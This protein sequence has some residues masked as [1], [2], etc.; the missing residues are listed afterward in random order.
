M[1][2]AHSIAMETVETVEGLREEH[3]QLV[4][5]HES[6][7]Q[8]PLYMSVGIMF[9]IGATGSRCR[10]RRLRHSDRTMEI[11][12]GSSWQ[13]MLPWSGSP[14]PD[15]FGASTPRDEGV[16]MSDGEEEGPWEHEMI[17]QPSA[18]ADWLV[19]PETKSAASPSAV[20]TAVESPSK[21]S[22][23]L[24]GSVE[25]GEG[26]QHDQM[27]SRLLDRLDRHKEIAQSDSLAA[28]AGSPTAAP[29][30]SVQHPEVE[31]LVRG[32]D[33]SFKDVRVMAKEKLNAFSPSVSWTIPSGIKTP[34][35]PSMAAKRHKNR[36]TVVSAIREMTRLKQLDGNHMA[37][38]M[39]LMGTMIDR[40]MI[41]APADW[42]NY[43]TTELAM[44]RMHGIERAFEHAKQ[45]SDWKPPNGAKQ[46]WKSESTLMCRRS[47]TAQ[48]KAVR[49]RANAAARSS[50]ALTTGCHDRL[51]DTEWGS[52][53]EWAMSHE[54]PRR[55]SER[56]LQRHRKAQDLR[57]HASDDESA[58]ERLALRRLGMRLYLH[59]TTTR[60]R[61][62]YEKMALP[63][64]Q[65]DETDIAN[66]RA[67]TDPSI[68][69]SIDQLLKEMK[70]RSM[71]VPS[72]PRGSR[73]LRLTVMLMSFGWSPA[74]CHGALEN[75]ICNLHGPPSRGQ[76]AHGLVPPSFAEVAFIYWVSMD[77]FAS[78]ALVSE[79]ESTI[80]AT[81]K[82]IARPRLTEVGL[83][84]HMD[85]PGDAIPLSL[86][87][88][89][90][91]KPHRLT[92]AGDKVRNV[93]GATRALLARGH[94]T[95]Q[96]LSRTVGSWVWSAM[97]CRSAFCPLD[98][99]YTFATKYGGDQ[100]RHELWE[101]A[102]NAQWSETAFAADASETGL[103][104]A[105]IEASWAE[106]KAEVDRQRRIQQLRDMARDDEEEEML[107]G[108]A[109]ECLKRSFPQVTGESEV[110]PQRWM[111]DVFAG[112]GGF[113]GKVRSERQ[114]ETP[115][116]DSAL[117]PRRD[118]MDPSFVEVVCQAILNGLFFLVHMARR[119]REGNALAQAAISMRVARMA[120]SAGFS[121][122]NP[123]A[124]LIWGLPEMIKLMDQEGAFA[125]EI[126][127]CAFGAKWPKPTGPLA[128]AA[129]QK[130]LDCLC[131]AR[132]KLARQAIDA[133]ELGI[134]DWHL[135]RSPMRWF[136][137]LL[138]LC[139]SMATAGAARK[140]KGLP[141]P[142]MTQLRK[143]GAITL[144]TGARLTLRWTPTDM[145]PADGPSR[146]E[147]VGSAEVTKTKAEQ[148]KDV[149]DSKHPFERDHET[150][151]QTSGMD[152]P[153]NK[154]SF[155]DDK[156]ERPLRLLIHA[157]QDDAN[158]RYIKEVEPFVREVHRKP[159]P[160]SSPG[161]RDITVAAE[162]DRRCFAER[163]PLNKGT[164][165][166]HGLMHINPEWKS[167]MP[168]AL[169]ALHSWERHQETWEEGLASVDAI[170]YIS[171]EAVQR[172]HAD[173]GMVFLL[174][175]DCYLR[176][177]DWLQLKAEDVHVSYRDQA[178]PRSINA[179]ILLGRRHRG[180]SVKTY[181]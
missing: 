12:T 44:W 123:G 23:S 56:V 51:R 163:A 133:R 154:I 180:E 47:R 124:P 181:R 62:I 120:A 97:R 144:A 143:I 96:E 115:F 20:P 145:N 81:V 142:L 164:M 100:G 26:S 71:K 99:R 93:I 67:Y 95:S 148:K 177:Q 168:N 40:S 166:H 45:R 114:C 18:V 25:L 69:A 116:V 85:G 104:A 33:D 37:E 147:S 3:K 70:R 105:E 128:N 136:R 118:L 34:V 173:E 140:I 6:G 171:R 160:F 53:N 178:D 66:T 165:L 16:A 159:L 10:G 135:C 21:P 121:P 138:V 91:E 13:L 2:R 110:P 14:S 158:V 129:A 117:D 5:M 126:A 127:H 46:E 106:V 130:D 179:A 156:L 155:E 49:G 7:V 82:E 161:E 58:F 77:E 84:M 151:K 98:S 111:A 108:D 172:G 30:A 55:I 64:R 137:E 42:I 109:L 1:K 29:E 162:L 83:D 38:E 134:H 19:A 35:A 39:L 74:I 63:P 78:L 139:D 113:G 122:E 9:A 11:E 4:E 170:Y 68:R 27:M 101:S 132:A 75:I 131:S 65:V 149:L 176:E 87:A 60:E 32:L 36:S 28:T 157:T 57:M 169:R 72:V 175:Y 107:S 22:G 73:Y 112:Y 15:S 119:V 90:A 61:R 59:R 102:L 141:R 17:R 125:V 150:P 24:S 80:M 152:R 153:V 50:T 76:L 31:A 41:E 52:A 86:G 48:E 146:G 92:A 79:D 103:G 88:T 43:K 54:L 174:A 94:A 167:E 8:E 89:I